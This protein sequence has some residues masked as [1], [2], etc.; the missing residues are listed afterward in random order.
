MKNTI[1][2]LSLSP[3]L[4]KK[5]RISRRSTFEEKHLT[6]NGV[7]TDDRNHH[8][9]QEYLRFLEI[10]QNISQ[11]YENELM[12]LEV[13]KKTLQKRE[14]LTG[15]CQEKNNRIHSQSSWILKMV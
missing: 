15:R 4:K 5:W 9:R 3:Q 11:T 1:N 13:C 14:R 7:H 6:P 10:L 12:V 8:N 2:C